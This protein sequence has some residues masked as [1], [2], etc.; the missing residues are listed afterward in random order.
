MAEFLAFR[1]IE[2]R[3]VAAVVDLWKSCGLVV[4]QNDPFKDIA[5]ARGKDILRRAGRHRSMKLLIAAI[6]VGHDGHRGAFYYVAVAPRFQRRG[7]GSATIRAGETW[8]RQ[9]GVWKV[10]L[11]RQK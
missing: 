4:A 10:N 8:L 7:Y 6:M 5:L 3:D 1:P 2:D 11:A 9:R